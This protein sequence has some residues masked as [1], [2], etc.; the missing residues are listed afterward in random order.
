VGLI[1]PFGR[2]AWS[3]WRALL[4][5]RTLADRSAALPEGL[6]PVSAVRALGAVASVQHTSGDAAIALAEV[7]ARGALDEA[8]LNTAGG[9]RDGSGRIPTLIAASKGAVAEFADALPL[10]PVATLGA[11]LAERLPIGPVRHLTAACA[12]S[13]IALHEARLWMLEEDLPRVLVVTS[14][15]ALTPMFIH[16]YKRLGVLPPLDERPLRIAPLDQQRAGFIPGEIGAAMVL[17]R[18]D[19]PDDSPR[20]TAS[21]AHPIRLGATAAAAEATDLIRTPTDR[22]ALRHVAERLLAEPIDL[23][24]PHATGTVENDASELACY[25]EA[26]ARRGPDHVR[27]VYACKGAL[28]HGLGSAGLTA[29]VLAVLAAR[30][31]RRPPMGWLADPIDT[32]LPLRADPP[33]PTGPIQRQALFA[34]GFG[35]HVAGAV[36]ERDPA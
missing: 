31:G 34:A 8:G 14:E 32:P 16:S 33:E 35:G 6:D 5:G 15:A 22:A 36:L 2:S 27:D 29:A 9:A 19:R 24:H 4:A 1:C 28:G 26:R 18:D 3:T 21:G 25:A 20:T 11:R 12:S 10:G 7:A 17:Q 23:L 30:T 13:L